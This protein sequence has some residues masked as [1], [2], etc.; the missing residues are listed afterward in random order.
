MILIIAL[1]GNC[2]FGTGFQCLTCRNVHL[3]QGM[4]LD[5]NDERQWLAGSYIN[6]YSRNFECLISNKLYLECGYAQSYK[7]GIKLK[8]LVA[9]I[10]LRRTPFPEAILSF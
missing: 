5:I 4:A 2:L 7:D 3:H 9:Q 8:G 10:F 1:L 6:H